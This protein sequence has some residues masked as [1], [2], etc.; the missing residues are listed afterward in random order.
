MRKMDI[1]Q[2]IANYIG[3]G[4]TIAMALPVVFVSSLC[5]CDKIFSRRKL[6]TKQQ[7]DEVA[8]RE[9]HKLGLDNEYVTVRFPVPDSLGDSVRTDY[10]GQEPVSAKI[11]CWSRNN[12]IIFKT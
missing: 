2:Q 5:I 8:H 11:F 1:E 9:M 3:V 12:R 7:V 4:T 10:V 6:I